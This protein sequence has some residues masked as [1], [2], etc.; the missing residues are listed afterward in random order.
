MGTQTWQFLH[1]V[2]VAVCALGWCSEEMGDGQVH[3]A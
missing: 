3:N 1:A 2:S